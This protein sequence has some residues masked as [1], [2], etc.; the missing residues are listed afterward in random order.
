MESVKIGI[1]GLGRL[2]KRHA[3]NLRFKVPGADLTAACSIV[4]EEL[5][6]AE[7]ELDITETYKDYEE[8]LEKADLDAVFLVTSSSMHAGQSI[9][10]LEKGL[11]VFTEKPMG[12]NLEE[13]RKVENVVSRHGNLVFFVG[14]VRRF[15]PS[16][17]YA[18]KLIDEGAIGEPFLVRSQTVDLDEYA[19]FQVDFVPS[20][21]GIFL[22]CNVHDIDL[23]RWFLGS[24]VRTVYSKGGSY[25]HKVFNEVNDADNTVVLATF[26]DGKM[27]VISASRT[28][29]HGH[30]THTEITGSRGILKIGMTPAKNRV[31]V[32]D[33]HGA[34]QEC[35]KDFFERFQEGFLNEA[36]EFVDCIR[37]GRKPIVSARDGMKATEVGFAMTDSFRQ[38][39]EIVLT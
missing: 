8:M 29:F 32:F 16:Y 22:D 21:G 2:G 13:C 33:A 14:F 3:M 35:V 37:E 34:R 7:K 11:H 18:R 15:D 38:G 4:A 17:A 23:A 25:V 20:S 30:D 31:E 9:K 1:V 19:E 28:A 36:Q 27:A 26:E 12:I 24:E 39:R 5:A 10:A 6:W